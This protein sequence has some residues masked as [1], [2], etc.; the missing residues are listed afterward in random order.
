MF[1]TSI[2]PTI[3]SMTDVAR[4]TDNMLAFVLQNHV[5]H[6]QEN[7]FLFNKMHLISPLVFTILVSFCL[8]LEY[9]FHVFIIVSGVFSWQH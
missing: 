8:Q 3:S 6:L 7:L 9:M 2:Y 1:P 4:T 5:A